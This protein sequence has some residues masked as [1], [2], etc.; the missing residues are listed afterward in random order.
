MKIIENQHF[1]GERSLFKL[2]DA[3]LIN[4]LF[5]NGESPLKE[6]K[7]LNIKSCTFSYKYPLWY[8]NNFHVENSAFNILS[9][10]GI[11][12]TN[13]STFINNHFICPK[14]FRHTNNILI[15]NCIFEDGS[16]TF[17][18]SSNLNVKNTKIYKSSNLFLSSKNITLE[19]VEIEGDYAFINASN[20]KIKNVTINGNYCFDGGQ[21]IYIEDS[22]LNSKDAFWNTKNVTIKN[23][24]I[25]GEYLGWNTKNI[26]FINCEII[27][28]QGLCYIDDLYLENCTITQSDLTF[29]YCS[30]IN[31]N[32]IS[33]IDSVKNPISGYIKCYKI[34][35]YIYDDPNLDSSKIKI[36][37][38]LK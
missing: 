36:K 24:K 11:W 17:W 4:C 2:E 1:E 10:S 22:I 27:S 8:G 6:S 15:D 26:K 29:E 35:E 34:K 25:I 20:I 21:D 16:E 32:I 9:R 3:T 14:L 12:Y 23:C 38:T 7:N 13:N 5:D 37:E 30:N 19:N 33:E 31:A 18:N 28:H